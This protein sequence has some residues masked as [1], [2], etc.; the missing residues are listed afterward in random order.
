MRRQL[1]SGGCLLK[2]LM[3]GTFVRNK[4]ENRIKKSNFLPLNIM[5][6]CIFKMRVQEADF[7]FL[8]EKLLWQIRETPE[9]KMPFKCPPCRDFKES[10]CPA[11]NEGKHFMDTSLV[12]PQQENQQGLRRPGS[13]NKDEGGP[14]HPSPLCRGT[15]WPEVT[16]SQPHCF[17]LEAGGDGRV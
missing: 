17:H 8:R 11:Q 9:M 3:I 14:S 12:L 5:I 13:L 7:S 16:D 2:L 1:Y 10:K 4:L 6:S 15:R